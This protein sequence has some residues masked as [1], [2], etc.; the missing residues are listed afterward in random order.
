[1]S[2]HSRLHHHKVHPSSPPFC[3][4]ERVFS[5]KF[6]CIDTAREDKNKN[7]AR[8]IQLLAQIWPDLLWW[9]GDSERPRETQ[10][11][12]SELYRLGLLTAALDWLHHTD[13]ARLISQLFVLYHHQPPPPLPTLVPRTHG[14]LNV[15]YM[16]G[17]LEMARVYS[18]IQM[19][20]DC[21]ELQSDLHLY[22][23]STG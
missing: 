10:T 12:N 5:L 4:I 19:L 15:F 17:R 14:E 7:W 21:T 20:S 13:I 6:F 16:A 8:D 9:S 1:M 11:A 18:R 2:S 23:L 22:C 3:C